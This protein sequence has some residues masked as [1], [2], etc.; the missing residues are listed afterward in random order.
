[1]TDTTRPRATSAGPFR[2]EDDTWL[3]VPTTI[4]H[5]ARPG[6]PAESAP[7]WDALKDDVIRLQRCVVCRRYTHYPAG[8]CQWCGGAVEYEQV[9]GAAT[10]NTWTMCFVEFGPGMETPYVT[11]IVN[12]DCEPGLQ[13]MTNLVNVRVSDIR[14]GMQVRPRIVHDESRALLLYEPSAPAADG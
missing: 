5:R 6:A 11:A 2:F 3:D 1:M 14:I 10:V 12:P 4:A 7:F 13:I 9:D 8:G